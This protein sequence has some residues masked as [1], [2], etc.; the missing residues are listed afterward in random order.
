L[1]LL[2]SLA[3]QAGVLGDGDSKM[4]GRGHACELDVRARPAEIGSDYV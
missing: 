3:E 2:A 4:R 1:R